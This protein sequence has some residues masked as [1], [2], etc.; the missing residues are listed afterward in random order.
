MSAEPDELAKY[1]WLV[2]GPGRTWLDKLE[3]AQTPVLQL[4]QRLRKDLAAW[5]THLLVN[6]RELRQRAARKFPRSAEMFFTSVAL[7]QSTDWEVACYKSSRFSDGDVVDLCCGIGGDLM[8]L[9]QRGV[10]QG[11]DIDPVAAYLAGTNADLTNDSDAGPAILGIA[12]DIAGTSVCPGAAIHIDPDRRPS[13]RRTIQLDLHRPGIATL[14][15]LIEHPA[16]VAIKLA[17]ATDTTHPLLNDAALEW[18][19]HRREC[20]Q[21]VAWFG[22]LQQKISRYQAT[23]LVNGTPFSLHA[24]QQPELIVDQRVGS[25]LVEP[26][27]TVLAADMAGV[28]A[29]QLNLTALTPGGGYLSGDSPKEGPWWSCFQVLEVDTFREKRMASMLRTREIGP[30]EIKKRGVDVAVGELQRRLSR[31]EG[32]PATLFLLRK[33]KGNSSYSHTA[34]S[35]ETEFWA[36]RM[37]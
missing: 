17:P 11:I 35:D 7:Q 33:G 4:V 10:A 3:D 32:T 1:T 26:E 34:M 5:Q 36:K 18:I 15:Q 37:R 31:P 27:P 9:C 14:A 13:G 2:E 23:V 30:L 16:G 20:Q 6:Q 22:P 24:N 29:E 19:G 28:V 12:G 8:A 25:Y 21:L